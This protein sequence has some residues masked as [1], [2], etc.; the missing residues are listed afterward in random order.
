M[1]SFAWRVFG[2]ARHAIIQ[3]DEDAIR[4]ELFSIERLEQHARSLAANQPVH[5]AAIA[6]R[7]LVARLQDNERV[8][9]HAY[10]SI[11]KA[12]SEGR[13]VTPAAEWLLDNFHLVEQQVREVR[14][15]LPAGYYRELPKLSDGPLAGYPRVFGLVWAFVAHT[16]S[17]FEPE[18]LTRFVRAYQEVQPLNIGELWAVAITLRIV[19]VENLRRSASRI[20]SQRSARAQADLIADRLLGV[21]DHVAD[22]TALAPYEGAPFSEGFAVQLV[23][24]LRDQD[25][26]TT[27]AVRWLERRLVGEGT[28]ADELVRREHQ[29]QGATNVTVRN[30]ITSMRLVSDVDWA[31]IFEA[32][33]PVDDVL[34]TAGVF[35]EMDFATRNL[36][37]TAIEEI[38]R[39]TTLREPEVAKRALA[40]ASS[41]ARSGDR[42][43]REREPGYH[44]IGGG[45]R[46]FERS[47]GFRTRGL[48]LRRRFTRTGIWGYV[49]SIVAT[50]GIVLLA[51]LLGLS[52]LGIHGWLLVAM[53]FAGFLP[54]LDTALL[55]VNRLITGGFGAT[56][57]PGL[58]L[59]DGVPSDLRTMVAI[60]TLLSSQAAIDEQIERLEVHHL[61]NPAGALH[62]ALLSDWTDAHSESMPEDIALLSTARDGIARLNSRYPGTDGVD[63]FFLLHRRRGW[64][65]VQRRW[66]GWE[67][68]RGKLH[69]FNQLLRG[70]TGTTFLEA[71]S[72][73][74][75]M[76]VRYVIT[77]DSDTRLPRD[78]VARLVGKMAHPLN[79]PRLDVAKGR[80]VEGYG[81]LQPRVTPSLPVGTEGSLFQRVFSSNSG[82][83][84]YASAVSD[85][86]QDLFGEGS[87][88]GKGIYDIDAFEAALQGRVPDSTMLSHDLF[89]GIFARSGLV[90]DIEVV[91]EFPAHYDVAAARQHRWARGDWQLLPWMMGLVKG[92]ATR[93]RVGY[94]PAIG[95]WKMFDNLRRTLSAPAALLALLV[96]WTLPLP[97]AIVWTAFV[98][99]AIAMPT[100]LPVVGALFPR[101]SATTTRSHLGALWT[102]ILA[103]FS[104][105]ALLVVFLA[106]HAWLM[107]DAIGRTLFR[108][109]ISQRRLLEWITAAQSKQGRRSGWLG[110]YAK[111]AGSVVIAL[112]TALFVGYTGSPA[113]PVAAPFVLAWLFAPAIAHW[114]SRPPRD[115]GS[116]R[117]AVED[118]LSLR[119]VARRTWRFFET[120]VTEADHM[121]PPDNFQED[122][123]PVLARRT[124]PTNL[125]LLLLSTAAAREFGWISTIEAVERIEATLA[126]MERL[127]RY[128]GHFFNWYDTSD[129][130][131]LEPP[132]ISTVDSGNL[133]GHLI[134]LANTCAAWRGGMAIEPDMGRG[135]ADSL[136]LAREAL[137]ALP[138]DRRTHLVTSHELVS[139]LESLAA[140]LLHPSS[141]PEALLAHATTAVD[142]ARTLASE[143]GDTESGDMLYWVEAAHRSIVSHQRGN[144]LTVVVD[145]LERRLLTIETTARATANAMEFDFLFDNRRRLLSIGYLAVEDRL[146]SNC[147]DLLAS[148][149]RLASFVAIAAGE[150]PARHWFRLGREVT[151]VGRG[152]ALVSWSGSMFEYLMPSLVMRAP[153]GSL[154]EKTNQLIVRRQM[155][156]ATALGLPWGISESA[157]NARDKEFT[158]QYSNFGVPGLGFKRGLSENIVIAPY[159]TALAAMVDPAA[160]TANFKRLT[161]RGA[162]ARYGF[163]EAIDFTPSRLP[164]GESQAI[165]R[166]YMAHHQGMVVVAIANAL[167]DGVMRSRFHAEPKVQATELLLQERAPRDVAVAH[168]RAEEVGAGALTGELEPAVVRRLHNPHAASPSVHLLSNG[169]YSVMLT[170]A[171][172]GYSQWGGHAV[173]RWREDTTRDDYGS[174]IFLRDIETGAVWSA[175]HQPCG[176]RPDRYDVMF[177]EDRAEFVRHDGTL[178]TSLDVVVSPEDDAEVRRVSLVNTGAEPRTIELTSYAEIVLASP[179]ADAAHQ[180]FSKL[181]VHTEYLPTA[182]AILATRRRR[183]PD[184]PELWAAHLTAVEGE[185]VGV[186]E[187]ETDRARFLGRGNEVGN[188]VAATDGRR[189]SGT[190][191]AVLDPVFALRRRLAIPAG[192]TAR[193]AFWTVVASSREALLDAIDKHQDANAFTR[194]TTLAWTQ[195]QVQLRHLDVTSA[196]ASH[197]QRLAGHVLYANP[198][199]R[200]SPGAI[201]RGLAGPPTLW[202][203]GISGDLP[204]VLV[205][206]DEVEDAGIVREL[207]RAWE[208]WQLKGLAVDLVILN[209]R[210]TSYVQDLQAALETLV[211]ASRSRTHLGTGTEG[212]RVFV[213]RT[214]LISGES[215]ALLLALARVVIRGGRGTL[216]DQIDRLRAPRGLP[217]P[218]RRS[219]AEID[220]KVVPAPT[221]ALDGLQFFNGLGGFSPDGREY[222]ITLGP[223]QS[224]PTPWINV[225]S[226]PSFG[227][228]VAAEGGG[229]T[230]SQNSRDNQ[231]TPWS[232]DP[233]INR[234]GESLYVHDL[235]SG[236]LWGPTAQPIHHNQA[237]YIARHGRGY[238]RFEVTANGIALELLQYVPLDDPIKVS[239]LTLHNISDRPRRLSVTSYVE[240]VLGLSRGAS[241]PTVVTERDEETGAIFA[242][243]KWNMH[244]GSRVAFADLAG[245]QNTWTGDRGEFIG[246]N[247]TADNPAA[248]TAAL[249]LSQRL[250]AGLDPCAALQTTIEL[251]SGSS[252]EVVFFLGQAAD[253]TEAR[254]LIA[255]YR[256]ADL[257]AVYR[258]V[259]AFWDEV[260]GTV[261]V[262]TPDRAMD[263]L[264]NGWLLY[265]SLACR[266]WARS[267]FYQA[268]GAY[269]FRDQL[270]DVMS[271]AVAK[272]ELTRDHVLRAAARQFVEGDVQHWWFPIGGHG[273]RTRI[274]D[275]RAWLAAV[276][277]HYLRTTGDATILDAQVPFIDGPLLRPGEH[278]LYFQPDRTDETAS[279]FE[280]C[281]RGLDGSLQTGVHGLPLMGTGDWNDGMNRVGE[282]GQ[283]E[284]V[285][286]GWFLYAALTAFVPLAESRGEDRRAETWKA[287][288]TALQSALEREAWDGGWYRRGY[289]DDGTPLG[290]A[291]SE[292]CRI[293]AIAQSW[294][295]ISAAA[296]PARATEAMEAMDRLLI[297]RGDRLALLFAPPF[298]KTSLDPG[299]IKGYPPGIREN[300]GQYTHA[301]AWSMMAFATLGEG[302]KAIELFSLLNPIN[303][304]SSRAGVLRYK[305]EPYVVAADVYSMPPHVGRGGWTWY[306]GS[307]GW[308][309]RA[310]VESILGLR[311]EGDW[312]VIDPCVATSWPS[313]EMK[314]RYR[315]AVYE[316]VVRNPQGVSRGV[317]DVECDGAPQIPV[318][319]QA[320]IRL[321]EDGATHTVVVTLGLE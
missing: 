163:Y 158:Y 2:R 6:G 40:A 172:S 54:A 26:D 137:L 241:A 1:K 160:A 179:V 194:A 126:T 318:H 32:V 251:A 212:A 236:D 106:H 196:E 213:L 243:N 189:L 71:E 226:N 104:Q 153:F 266:Y 284:S 150:I 219:T 154:L 205:R 170:A 147:Y 209:E 186:I 63:R 290:S 202:A 16:D 265:Q 280:H 185:V 134:A 165:V 206:I 237:T 180:A 222:V 289:Y 190:V 15:D 23:Q 301:A 248:L 53:A 120:F 116:L 246:R 9:L 264:L 270:Q 135:A 130:R 257:G 293:D 125:G 66:I 110:L 188:A 300:G 34:R 90:S 103:S 43:G 119:L 61:S 161:A 174:Y 75:P 187:V 8:L 7:S 306:T 224:T 184:E 25:P 167:L 67:R 22:P 254:A 89:E 131:P 215:R 204:I 302:N 255:R 10:R 210:S 82:I 133:A 259:V 118:A 49:S 314:L 207:L 287:H 46:I 73:V 41:S 260:L 94:V 279:L 70:A 173:T 297:H 132:Y 267:G 271:L 249:P 149:A 102:D 143:R 197:Y 52:L 232:N 227:F 310:G 83:D 198:A 171:G 258:E 278:D 79:R 138:D 20:V 230:W 33:S 275:D 316:I 253:T 17:L 216:A 203:Q 235:E 97:G 38:A 88:S 117:V 85:V 221:V 285:W 39:G 60:P 315:G 64:N 35:V 13:S 18:T 277:A 50:T 292:E 296:D 281:A 312:L 317:I 288:A 177:A 176:S 42:D 144:A 175:T 140:A 200:S 307:A 234:P 62:F 105:T 247:G 37:R 146:D 159:A 122:P 223:G 76:D 238:S 191:G 305:V 231:L 183:G 313:F 112:L 99:L 128:R 178:V 319:G 48:T 80:V 320:R 233:V 294:A 51:P 193:I 4:S 157:Y 145:D 98:L 308:V 115:A 72:R 11:A 169:R 129:L 57:L 299:Y 268:S 5:K 86:Y 261:Q 218:Q 240:W 182:G 29:L 228:Q 168:P 45:R 21:K 195:A 68:K 151:P 199:L 31:R 192:G 55:L 148:E 19:L 114:V 81:V 136:D 201:S 77:L 56:L 242:R 274:S 24:R 291:A 162:R 276:V 91:E 3:Q 127:K 262:K 95:F 14:T 239:R 74:L 214:D 58:A 28:S 101:H 59:R 303:H 181:F 220:A 211:R 100:L 155:Q 208:Y 244:H 113:L 121:L 87:Y 273:V 111:M 107:V 298:D 92:T 65:E 256:A 124:S 84:P 321:C 309:Y 27:P 141:R 311:L 250:G 108:L 93:A 286:L 156:Y 96:G 217:P 78:A 272:P 139:A 123:T 304:T 295:A 283:G 47:V 30:I 263:I 36:Y 245:R 142:L 109:V 12:A 229:Y 269:G 152:A 44:L 166:A 225:V 252:Q 69:E 164:D 282:A